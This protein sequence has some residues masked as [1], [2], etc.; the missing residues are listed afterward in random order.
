ML[1]GSSVTFIATMF[2]SARYAIQNV[3]T[4][5]NVKGPRWY[6]RAPIVSGMVTLYDHL[7]DY[8]TSNHVQPRS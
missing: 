8:P 1:D 3:P 5:L 4:R 7:Q 6:E 2:C